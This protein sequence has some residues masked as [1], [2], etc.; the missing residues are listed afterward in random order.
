M[1]WDLF[2][3][4]FPKVAS[5]DQIPDDF[6]PSPV[7]ARDALIAKVK[8]VF[9]DSDFSD[10]SWGLLER[11]G[12]S[13]EINLGE[14]AICEDFALH[15]R[16]G[17]PGAIHGVGVILDATG[18]RAIDAQ[19]GEF[20]DVEAAEASFERWQEYRDKVVEPDRLRNRRETF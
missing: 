14:D 16:G 19:T 3:Q 8:A 17:G 1:S 11:D 13:I 20:F 15:V 9:L 4:D 12:W 2:A 18:S 7:G 10:P 5:V 6:R